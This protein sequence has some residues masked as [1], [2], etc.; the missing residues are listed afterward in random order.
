MF[1][2]GYRGAIVALAQSVLSPREGSRIHT[3]RVRRKMNPPGP[4][5][6]ERTRDA[7]QVDANIST[8]WGEHCTQRKQMLVPGEIDAETH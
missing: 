4:S 3:S 1:C 5:T 7:H 8:D 2:T 6:P